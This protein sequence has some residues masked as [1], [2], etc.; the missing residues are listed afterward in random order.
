MLSEIT[1]KKVFN[2]R[3][4]H[5]T[6]SWEWGEVRAQTP[7]VKKVLRLGNS[8]H[9]FQLTFHKLL[10]VSATVAYLP[11]SP[12][13]TAEELKSILS[14]CRKEKAIFL[15]IEADLTKINPLDLPGARKAKALLPLH[16]IFIDLTLT[17]E[18]LLAQ[19]HEK[20]RYNIRL[21]QRKGVTVKE[22]NTEDGLEKFIRLLSQTESRQGFY[23]HSDDYYRNL[24]K[25]LYPAG[26]A[27]ILLAYLPDH[28]EPVAGIMLYQFKKT[29]YYPYG[30]SNPE[31]RSYMAPQLI[32]FEAMKL[33]KTLGCTSY[34]LW[35]SYK[36]S[37][38]DSDPWAGI[39]RLK[40][41]FG[42]KEIDYPQ[43]IDIPLTSVYHLFQ[44][45][46]SMRWQLLH[47][48]RKLHL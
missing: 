15:Q 30:G 46:N 38:K 43:T 40:S 42:G 20:T 28:S 29:L 27:H 48:K 8:K 10:Q 32:H 25:I 16:T 13:P 37:K 33:G 17:E 36:Y 1:N 26:M 24:W 41:G 21:A 5:F 3:A 22:E 12:L 44:L 7:S 35:G 9:V 23:A 14:Y 34:D 2:S 47:L 45:G 11:R 18:Q 31:F 39:Y 19:M 6:Q 4:N